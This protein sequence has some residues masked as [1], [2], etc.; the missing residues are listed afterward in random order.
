[1]KFKTRKKSLLL[2]R[3]KLL[4]F[5]GSL[6]VLLLF[7]FNGICQQFQFKFSHTPISKA[8]IEVSSKSNIRIAFDASEL[9]KIFITKNVTGAT[10][11]EVISSVLEETGY[12]FDYK[13]GTYLII[14][15]LA[16]TKSEKIAN[17][18]VSGIV[19]DKTTGERLPYATLLLLEKNISVYAN[20]N[21]NFSLNLNDSSSTAVQVRYMGYVALD[22]V[23]SLNNEINFLKLGLQAKTQTIQAIEIK[24]EK[25]EM[26]DV[27]N[28][29]GHLSFN[30]I[31]FDDLPNYGE[32]DVFRSLQLLPG[33]SAKENSS[34]LNIRGSSA[35]QNLVLFDGF[36]L[37]NLDHFFGVFSALNPN[38]IKNIQVY[39][40]GFDSR[41]GERVSGIVDITGK[42]GNQEK[43]TFYGGINLI[44]ANLAAEIPV[45]NKFTIVAAARRAYSDIYSSWLA[46]ALLADKVKP[47]RRFQSAANIIEP[48]FYFGD[49]NLKMTYTPNHTEN[50][51]FSI[52][53]AKDDLNS[54][55]QYN[56]NQF[57]VFTED[58]NQWGNY[59]F[60]ISW[61][62]Q[63]NAKYFTN[64]QVGH[65]GYFN[66]YYNNTVF[67]GEIPADNFPSRIPGLSENLI[68]NEENDLIDYFFSMQNKFVFNRKNQ[69]EFGMSI[70]Y[71]KYSFYKDATS[72]FIY[73]DTESSAMLYN[74]YFQD[75]I[76][77]V[78]NLSIKPGLRLNYYDGTGKLYLE[79]R[80][81]INYKTKKNVVF[82]MASGKY[83]QYLNKMPSEQN[84][85]YNRDFWVLSDDEQHPTVSSNHFI[86]GA[87]YEIKHLF[88]DVEVYY[89]SVKGLQEYLFYPSPEERSP[90]APIPQNSNIDLSK[91]I[92]GTGKAI[93]IDFL[94]KYENTSFT[95]WLSYSLSKSTR[96]F[97]EIN[98]GENIPA[99]FDQTHEIKWT[100]IY[101]Y[102][103]WNF[104]TLALF[105]TGH[106]YIA[107]TSKDD[108][109]N[110]IRIYGR[111]PDYFRIDFSLNYNFNIK[112]VNIK[113]GLSIL[114]VLNT[115]N[116]LDIYMRS[117]DFGNRPVQEATLVKA[118]ELTLNF[119]INFRF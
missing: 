95:S 63:Q 66:D 22:T 16:T 17:K 6:V 54:S 46:D 32:T 38:V 100:N 24:G 85:G 112:N 73:D 70:K 84:F 96:N 108:Y 81:S 86:L 76:T 41:Y 103:K 18:L 52:Y 74:L 68:V 98:L 13:H 50:I 101:S 36:T 91:F 78:K 116:Y 79:P 30:P 20:V 65:S 35:D 2:I 15:S 80:F 99:A 82:K 47:A 51:S 57:T 14:R 40:G 21:G 105:T 23:V 75:N 12:T 59:G 37:Y 89:K 93:G 71:N 1:M 7:P 26:I 110:T 87:N 69:F 109:F 55:N 28:D 31:R 114:N 10:V 43:P 56:N 118:Q 3:N 53:G 107:N 119:F 27:N 113:P 88:F 42:S 49:F 9:E 11:N 90:A 111:L 67:S 61:K 104:S 83:Y 62:K 34:Q 29:A 97:N 45:N 117:F 77:P 48:T 5:L 44:S 33:I 72:E 64:F 19:F 94:A 102:Q 92:S 115:E 58:L 60:G 8:L 39:L 106:P 25:I 4:H